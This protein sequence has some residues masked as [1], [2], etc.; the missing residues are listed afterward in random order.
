[1]TF[2]LIHTVFRG[3]LQKIDEVTSK[4]LLL[5]VGCMHFHSFPGTNT[6]LPLKMRCFKLEIQHR[7]KKALDERECEDF[8]MAL[9]HKSKLWVYRWLKQEIGFNE[10]LEH[11]NRAPW[12]LSLY[13]H[14]STHGLFEELGRHVKRVG[15]QECP[16]CEVCKELVDCVLFECALYESQRQI[17]W[18]IW[19]K[20]FLWIPLKPFFVAAFLIKPHFCKSKVY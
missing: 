5:L 4:V 18:S 17:F 7:F 10:N 12:K 11:V 1:M 20:S 9:E 15:S 2:S 14:S 16:N 13:F 3:H 19:R 6:S 8:E